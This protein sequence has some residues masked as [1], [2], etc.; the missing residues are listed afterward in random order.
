[1]YTAVRAV[2]SWRWKMKKT[3]VLEEVQ[4]P[5]CFVICVPCFA[6]S[7]GTRWALEFRTFV[8]VEMDV[9]FAVFKDNIVDVNWIG[10]A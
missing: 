2:Y 8:E 5:P 10:Y 6:T 9:E 4:V 1:M 7:R 3:L